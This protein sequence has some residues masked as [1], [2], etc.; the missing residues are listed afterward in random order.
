MQN[1]VEMNE[2]TKPGSTA[3]TP[4]TEATAANADS[5]ISA[6]LGPE[7]KKALTDAINEILKGIPF[8]G[9]YIVIVKLRWGWS[10]ILLL[11]G[12]FLAATTLAFTGLLPQFAISD[13]YKKEPGPTALN[14]DAGTRDFELKLQQDVQWE[15]EIKNAKSRIWASGVAISKLNPRTVSEKVVQG[16]NAQIV[17]V[18]PCG[19][20]VKQRQ[21]DEQNEAT[22]GRIMS[23]LESFY[24]STKDLKDSQKRSLQV[25]LA[26]VYPTMVVIIIDN[27]LYAYFCP[28]RAVCTSSPVLFFRNYVDQNPASA[29][30]F[31]EQHFK[32]V[33]EGGRLVPDFREPCP[34][35]PAQ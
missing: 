7:Q 18:D 21:S 15:A 27:D 34:A 16:V 31:F 28:Y 35:T 26:E 30:I 1:D 6:D 3:G 13:T 10:G 14:A 11:V 12:G 20:V 32:A 23:N 4:R 19:D 25:R 17:Y 22:T 9:P 33:F 24:S 5:V 8:I 2:G 29:A